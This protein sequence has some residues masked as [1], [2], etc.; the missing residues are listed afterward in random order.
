MADLTLSRNQITDVSALS[1]LTRLTYL[2]L[3]TNQI[4]DVRA[5]SGLTNLTELNLRDNEITDVSPLVGL[6]NLM[7]LNLTGN[8]GITNAAVLFSLQQEGTTIT[9]VTVPASVVF[10]DT[11][12]V[13]AVRSA[14][15]LAVGVSIPSDDLA[16]LIRLTA[17]N[18]GITDLT[19][20]ETL[21]V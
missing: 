19:G 16:S 14:L 2:D 18:Q 12:L 4:T 3:H 7:T 17:S 15:G 20:L 9:G 21:P 10:S 1:G 13:A 11:A 6:T 8:T 5:L